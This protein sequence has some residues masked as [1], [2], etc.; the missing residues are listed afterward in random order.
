M[1]GEIT[2][3]LG[4]GFDDLFGGVAMLFLGRD[5]VGNVWVNAVLFEGLHCREMY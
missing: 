1:G 3:R 2:L 5:W 4:L